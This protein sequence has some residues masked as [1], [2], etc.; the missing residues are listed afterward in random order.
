MTALEEMA[1]LLVRPTSVTLGV[2]GK[3]VSDVLV[4]TVRTQAAHASSGDFPILTRGRI[5]LNSLLG[6]GSRI[7]R[8]HRLAAKGQQAL[9]PTVQVLSP[10]S[11]R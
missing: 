10:G 8:P 3:G 1:Q 11:D 9:V 5:E 7:A 2:W 4:A 6:W